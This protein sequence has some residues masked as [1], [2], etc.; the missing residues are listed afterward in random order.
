MPIKTIVAFFI[1]LFVGGLIL[2]LLWWLIGAL[3]LPEPFGWVARSVMLVLIVFFLIDCLLSL[4]GK[5]FI[6]W[7]E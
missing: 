6:K 2:G 3:T 4:M 1:R 5:S 7:G